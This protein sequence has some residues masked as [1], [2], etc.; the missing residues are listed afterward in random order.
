MHLARVPSVSAVV[1][2]HVPKQPLH[3]VSM[4]AEA[5]CSWLGPACPWPQQA[6]GWP[7]HNNLTP[8]TCSLPEQGLL[9]KYIEIT[10]AVYSLSMKGSLMPTTCMDAALFSH[11]TNMHVTL[12]GQDKGRMTCDGRSGH[13]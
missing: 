11:C 3:S 2:E 8:S 6:Q 10:Y 13:P 4:H 9:L 1:L 7:G 5:F 12:L